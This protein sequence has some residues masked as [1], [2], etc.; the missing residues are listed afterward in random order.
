MGGEGGGGG[1][2]EGLVRFMGEGNIQ[3]ELE[4]HVSALYGLTPSAGSSST[5]SVRGMNSTRT[6]ENWSNMSGLMLS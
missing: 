4:A 6:L 2:G 1:A 3:L 5:M